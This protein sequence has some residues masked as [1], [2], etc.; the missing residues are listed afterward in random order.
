MRQA[1]PLLFLKSNLDLACRYN[2][3][4]DL[5]QSLGGLFPLSRALHD[6]SDAIRNELNTCGGVARNKTRLSACRRDLGAI[7]MLRRRRLSGLCQ[8]W[9]HQP[10]EEKAN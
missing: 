9:V 2:L 6:R 4:V 1:T 5:R 8:R 10:R 7:G 3:R